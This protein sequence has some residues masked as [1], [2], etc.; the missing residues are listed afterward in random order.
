MKRIYKLVSIAILGL[1]LASCSTET[2]TENELD[3]SQIPLI[4]IQKEF[5]I[6]ESEDFLPAQITSVLVDNDGQILVG[7]QPENSIFQFDSLGNY[8]ATVARPGRGPG[9]LSR[10][11]TPHINGEILVLSNNNSV[12]TEYH[13][14]DLGIYEFVRDHTFRSPGPVFGIRSE[15]DF[16]SFYVVVDSFRTPFGMVPPEY[17]TDFVNL[18]QIVNDS[19]QIKE[20]VLSLTKHSVYIQIINNGSGMRHSYLP[21]RYSDSF[22]PL[23]NQRVL[24]FRPQKSSIQV[25]D[26]NLNIEHELVLNVKPRPFTDED[27]DYHFSELNPD[28]KQARRQLIRDIKPPFTG[29]FMDEQN[30]FWLMVDDAENGKEYVILSYDGD[31]I[32]R[33]F[34][35]SE[36]TIHVVRNSKFY[37]VNNEGEPSIDVYSV[38]FGQ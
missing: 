16:S 10:Y 13:Q 4:E 21:Y 32:G 35:P 20:G 23:P 31:P 15:N 19:L 26:E 5:S 22:S 37:M 36:T 9:E 30:R 6:T 24:V 28:E 2:A 38:K 7:Q 11:A 29:G 18:V 33:F 25:Y 1:V 12:M 34:L 3:Y 8:R 27:M 14:N 17:E